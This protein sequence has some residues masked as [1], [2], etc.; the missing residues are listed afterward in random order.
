[1]TEQAPKAQAKAI[2]Y[3]L[4]KIWEERAQARTMSRP[5]KA[6]QVLTH[7][8]SSMRLSPVISAVTALTMAFALYLFAAFLLILGNV[9]VMLQG[10]SAA[11]EINVFLTDQTGAEQTQKLLE[12]L[13]A[14]PAL[15]QVR[16]ISKGEALQEFRQ[17]LDSQQG[18]LEGLEENNP[19]P[20]SI[21]ARAQ[22]GALAADVFK[23]VSERLSNDPRVGE[24]R[25][26]SGLLGQIAALLKLFTVGG[27]MALL[28]MLVM[29]AFILGSTI[30]LALF[31]RGEELDIMR[32]VGVTPAAIRAPCMV[33]GAILGF[34]GA[35]IGLAMLY[36]TYIPVS[37]AWLASDV[38]RMVLVSPEFISSLQLWLVLVLGIVVGLLGS[39]FA[40]RPFLVE[41]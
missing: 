22:N 20:A 11:V 36:L 9:G 21:R 35:V 10:G 13:R 3:G 2:A 12:E 25:Y 5:A 18:L 8:F 15:A 40:V 29:I 14:W 1:M 37:N 38:L 39:Y 6:W 19:L 34:A 27:G 32:L 24:V 28:V 23:Q 26:S 31:S 4:A 41:R 17:E 30:K 33:E 7:A 16:L